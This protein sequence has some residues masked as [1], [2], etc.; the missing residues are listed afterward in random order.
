MGALDPLEAPRPAAYDA[1][2]ILRRRIRC[3]AK[4]R[5]QQHFFSSETIVAAMVKQLG[6]GNVT[7]NA[8]SPRWASDRMSSMGSLMF[9]VKFNPWLNEKMPTVPLS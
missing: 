8:P 6:E 5:S 7:G 3:V 2:R 1:W 4:A 9:D